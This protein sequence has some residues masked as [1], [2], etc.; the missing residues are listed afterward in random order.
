MMAYCIDSC[1]L[2]EL[3]YTYRPT[4]FPSLMMDINKLIDAGKLYSAIEVLKE[5]EV[6]ES[7]IIYLW[8]SDKKDMFILQEHEI[9]VEVKNL[10]KKYPKLIDYKTGRSGA[11]P[12]LIA[13]A[14]V[15]GLA[16]VTE[17]GFSGDIAYPKIPDVCRHEKIDCIR[18]IDMLE[19]ENIKLSST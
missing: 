10:L 8:A 5:L 15:K 2:I 16:I 3:N 12:W 9:Q 18:L 6:Q 13:T 19:R 1:S 17:E 4:V 11:D 14:K 7:D